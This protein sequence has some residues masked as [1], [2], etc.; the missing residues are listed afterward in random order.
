MKQ[1]MSRPFAMHCIAC[2]SNSAFDVLLKNSVIVFAAFHG[3]MSAAELGQVAALAW[4]L[5]MAPFFIFSAHGGYLGDRF[6]K[7]KVA[8]GLRCADLAIAVCAAY[9]FLAGNVPLL[10]ALVFAKGTTSTLYSPIKYALVSD[11]LPPAG[12]GAGYALLE[13][14]SMAAILCATWFGTVLGADADA[15][16]IGIF[17]ILTATVSFLATIATPCSPTI[18]LDCTPVGLNPLRSTLQILRRAM[19]DLRISAAI[20]GLSWYWTLGAVFLS[21]VAVLVRHTLHGDESQIADI[22]V[23]FMLGAGL[24]LGAG[25]WLNRGRMAR[26]LPFAMA[27]LMAITG[28]DLVFSIPLAPGRMLADFFIIAMASGIYATHFS[29]LLYEIAGEQEKSRIFAAGNIMSSLFM[30]VALAVSTLIIHLQ[31]P[32]AICLALFAIATL[33]VTLL[34]QTMARSGIR[35]ALPEG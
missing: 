27:V 35:D 32:V 8:F 20:I 34:V 25:A 5:F 18:N 21:N 2:A 22:L 13:A 29:S 31:V 11:L 24:G 30:V 26:H 33:P 9:G 3:N 10:L 12:H 19:R 16:K 23:I 4:M 17:A 6:D 28:A 7:R 14:T 1:P 15:G